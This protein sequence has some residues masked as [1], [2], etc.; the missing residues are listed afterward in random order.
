MTLPT[1]DPF[2]YA[3]CLAYLKRSDKEVLHQVVEE[4]IHK[5][6]RIH[7]QDYLIQIHQEQ[8]GEL[9][10]VCLNSSVPQDIEHHILSYVEE[11]L[12]LNTDIKAFYIS[13]AAEPVFQPLIERLY[14]LRLIK[15]IDLFEA[16]SWA[17]IGQQINLPFAYQIKQNLVLEYGESKDIYGHRYH[18]FP[19]PQAIV[20]ASEDRMRELKCSRQKIKYLKIAAKAILEGEISKQSLLA[21]GYE[22]ARKKLISLKGIGNWS[23]NYVLMRCLGFSEGFPIEDAGLHQALRLNFHLDHKPTIDEVRSLTASWTQWQAYRTFYFWQ[24][25]S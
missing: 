17:I 2:D 25:L 13:V 11:W 15:V 9:E 12:D 1:P 14:G 5:L 16:I 20:D 22:E 19:H 8:A 7:G 4:R 18:L 6:I 10:I 3:A 21:L 23:A 24:S